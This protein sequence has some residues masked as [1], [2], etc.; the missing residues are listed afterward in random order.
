MNFTDQTAVVTGGTRG[1][2]R[3]VSEAFLHAG[4]S[5][6]ATYRSN[7]EAAKAFQT[8][9]G[10]LGA[11]LSLARFDVTSEDAVKA[12]WCGLDESETRVQILVNNSGI[13][14]DHVMAMMPTADWRAVLDT[15][16]TGT[17]LM[18]K[19]AVLHMLRSRYGRV[20]NITSPA[21]QYG[22]EGQANYSASKAGQVAMGRSLSKEVAKRGITVNCVSPGFVATEL[23]DDLPP[24]AVIAHK[25]SV[26][27]KRFG[28]PEEI[29]Y[30]VL[31]LAAKEASYINGASLVVTGGL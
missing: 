17:F 2:G 16:L 7:D 12:F 1:I 22:F 25:K 14:R 18:A 21:G 5:V 31:A 26:P 30:A 23:I 20:I 19:S 10:D 13:R 15:N 29:A 9:L 24:E 4:A 3:A 11:R 8:G 28:K 6:I 27:M